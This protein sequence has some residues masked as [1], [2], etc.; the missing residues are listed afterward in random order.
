MSI[1]ASK[2]I[3]VYIGIEWSELPPS[4][5]DEMKL[6]VK[7]GVEGAMVELRGLGYDASWCGVGLDP[8]AAAATVRE[9]LRGRD[10]AGVLIGA[11]LRKTDSALVLF[12]RIVNEVHTSCP[13]AAI[14]FNST[15]DDSAAALRRW[16][17]VSPVEGRA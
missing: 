2:P 14:C 6:K 13:R 7:A 11:G 5:S 3:V 1:A 8:D 17:D 9:A 10:V 15:P 12:E 16:V 4:F